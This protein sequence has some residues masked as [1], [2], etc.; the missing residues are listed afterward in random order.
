MQRKFLP[1]VSSGLWIYRDQV[2]RAIDR[3]AARGLV[4]V[5]A[6]GGS[7]KTVALAQWLEKFRNK[8]AWLSLTVADNDPRIF[9]AG[10]LGAMARAQAA[11]RRLR[12]LAER[13]M[14]A[15]APLEFFLKALEA[16][17]DNDKIYRLV[18][19][20][21]HLIDNTE[22][23]NA[24][25][26]I[27]NHFPA[28]FT[29]II[30]SRHRA[31]EA[32]ADLIVKEEMALLTAADL[33]FS[34]EEVGGLGGLR[35]LNLA[36]GQAEEICRQ[37]GGWALGVVGQLMTGAGEIGADERGDYFK[38]YLERHIWQKFPAP[39]R[40][41]LLKSALIRDLSPAFCD[42]L[43]GRNDG[44]VILKNLER[45]NA[46]ITRQGRELY[47]L[48]DI[49][50]D[51]ILEKWAEPKHDP[52]R[53]SICG[54]AADWFYEQR[55]FFTAIDLYALAG[56]P[57]GVTRSMKDGSDYDVDISVERHLRFMQSL[58]RRKLPEAFVGENF[59]LT[60]FFAWG[61]FLAGDSENFLIRMDQLYQLAETPENLEPGDLDTLTFMAS[62]DFRRPLLDCARE[63]VAMMTTQPTPEQPLQPKANSISQNLPLMHRSMR[64][65]SELIAAGE[66]G[67]DL[68]RATFGFFIGP[69]YEILED[70]LRAGLAYEQGRFAQAQAVIS[71][72]YS[73]SEKGCNPEMRLCVLAQL[74]LCL[75]ALK[76]TEAAA[77]LAR[78]AEI[79]LQ[80]QN[81]LF[82]WPN[83]RALVFDAHLTAGDRRA[84]RQW[85]SKY[86]A[87]AQAPLYFHTLPQHFTSARARLKAGGFSLALIGLDRLKLMADTYRRPLDQIE[88]ETLR[89]IALWGL[90][91]AQGAL[92][93]L[94]A[95]LNL[96]ATFDY[97]RILLQEKAGLEPLWRRLPDDELSP[98]TALFFKSLMA[99][100][101]PKTSRAGFNDRQRAILRCLSRDLSNAEIA[102]ELNLSLNTVK[103][104]LK[105]IYK[106]LG[107][108]SRQEALAAALKLTSDGNPDFD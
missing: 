22:I 92:E 68:L 32:V 85:L 14:E 8:K 25:P 106:E 24:L 93:S 55:D 78:S 1:P 81:A 7:G 84:A 87:G 60:S 62:L 82:L 80:D 101:A 35:S 107:A 103:F 10:L 64:D 39:T 52:E 73:R 44:A 18:L 16:A 38:G 48:H 99:D 71:R 4:F 19:D 95:A 43:T 40:D 58:A 13:A 66:E 105:K 91:D 27:V 30:L 108:G 59:D 36:P 33:K 79:Y 70:C 12:A 83:F 90:S 47:R 54:R 2:S 57:S 49:F 75:V 11:G 6:P 26:L 23:I 76:E 94:K 29:L 9:Y 3:S 31:P 37:A 28:N 56:D 21:F 42:H 5:S 51:W 77:D 69:D 74:Y 15:D 89:A 45:E 72:A 65:Y 17:L 86:A 88:A 97:R 34:P 98:E 53:A 96:A 41:L 104:H 20:D 63:A 102:A 67:Y 46:F 100:L 50:R 61:Y